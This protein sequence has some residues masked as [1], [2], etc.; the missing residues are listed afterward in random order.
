MLFLETFHASNFAQVTLDFTLLDS[1]MLDRQ[2]QDLPYQRSGKRSPIEIG[3][4]GS[5]TVCQDAFEY[6]TF[7]PNAS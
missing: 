3:Y 4:L 5:R 1:E 6:T 7:I 2:P